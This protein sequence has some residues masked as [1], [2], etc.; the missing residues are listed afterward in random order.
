NRGTRFE[1]RC[2]FSLETITKH[3]VSRKR[4]PRTKFAPHFA[5]LRGHIIPMSPTTK[6][7]RKR[8]LKR[9]T[10]PTG[11]GATR[12]RERSTINLARIGTGRA[13]FSRLG[14]GRH[15]H[16]KADF[17]SG[18]V[19]AGSSSNLAELDS[20]TSSKRSSAAV[21]ADLLSVD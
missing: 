12:K 9:S 2:Q 16:P 15:S 3:S 4:P 1:S 6:R 10:K 8:I 14:D 7:P 18:A 5:S 19:T 11:C 20:A 17:T 13:D 21:A